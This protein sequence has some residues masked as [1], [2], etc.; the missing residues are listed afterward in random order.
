MGLCVS[1]CSPRPCKAHAAEDG[2]GAAGEVSGHGG[3]PLSKMD[4]RVR[5]K[6]TC[7]HAVALVLSLMCSSAA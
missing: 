3:A 7:Q 5:V 1:L 4:Q 2:T 6:R